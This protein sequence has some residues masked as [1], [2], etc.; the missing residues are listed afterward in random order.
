M[1]KLIFNII[2]RTQYKTT[3]REENRNL[4]CLYVLILLDKINS[5]VGF[6]NVV[7]IDMLREAYPLLDV[8]DHHR[9][10]KDTVSRNNNI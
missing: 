5:S 10:P 6:K 7:T 1:N 8:V 9:R 4:E 3:Y 2:M